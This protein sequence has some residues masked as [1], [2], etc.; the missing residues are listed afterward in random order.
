MPTAG[1]RLLVQRAVLAA[2]RTVG[3][4]TTSELFAA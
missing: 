3:Y 2:D 4:E 1:L